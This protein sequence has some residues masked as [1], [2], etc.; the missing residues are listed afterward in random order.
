MINL[1]KENMPKI[2]MRDYS[3]V[4]HELNTENYR[5]LQKR[6]TRSKKKLKGS[7]QQGQLEYHR[8]GNW[9]ILPLQVTCHLTFGVSSSY[10]NVNIDFF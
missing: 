8:M 7:E 3:T 6:N 2:G 10:F 9:S 4:K 1:K 5:S